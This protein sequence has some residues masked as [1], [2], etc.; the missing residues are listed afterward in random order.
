MVEL[1]HNSYGEIFYSLLNFSNCDFQ[2]YAFVSVFHVSCFNLDYFYV[3][4]ASWIR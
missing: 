2:S 1:I 3:F 4:S